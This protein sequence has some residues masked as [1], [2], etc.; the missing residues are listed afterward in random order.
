MYTAVVI[1]IYIY[2]RGEGL[3]DGRVRNMW[4]G[5]G[6]KGYE[7]GMIR[8]EISVGGFVEKKGRGRE[9]KGKCGKIERRR[10]RKK[11]ERR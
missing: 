6:W 10:E 5:R 8:R 9:E 3:G 11:L 7:R 1:D 4:R 2:I